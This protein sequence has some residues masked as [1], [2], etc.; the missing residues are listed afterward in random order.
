MPG[1]LPM[2]GTMSP[3]PLMCPK[4]WQVLIQFGIRIVVGSVKTTSNNN[5]SIQ[6]T[7][8]YILVTQI[9]IDRKK[10]LAVRKSQEK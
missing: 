4:E 1:H 6:N 3:K 10:Q 5:N 2:V 7:P 9:G 8:T